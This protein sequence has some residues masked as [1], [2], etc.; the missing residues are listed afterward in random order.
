MIESERN[1]AILYAQSSVDDA[2][3]DI[4][5][6]FC[7]IIRRELMCIY[8][9]RNNS[10][11]ENYAGLCDIACNMLK[12]KLE[13][14][15]SI[16][17]ANISLSLVHGEQSHHYRIQSKH[18]HEQHTWAK[19]TWNGSVFYVDPTASQFSE[20]Y[21]DIPAIYIS[22]ES[23][24][25]YYRDSVNPLFSD[26]GSKINKIIKI[27]VRINGKWKFIG[28]IEFFQY[29]IHG[30]ISDILHKILIGDNYE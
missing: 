8:N 21:P 11:H 25:W 27:P 17:D 14:Y 23:P 3:I 15:A 29:E 12:E 7:I 9:T 22:K 18:W 2:I 26:K 5:E 19:V 16:N 24:K 30:R 1:T 20:Y 6:R 10:N 4:L 28:I 13:N